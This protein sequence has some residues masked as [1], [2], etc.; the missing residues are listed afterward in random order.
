MR[1]MTFA[2]IY[3]DIATAAE[4]DSVGFPGALAARYK[5]D[6]DRFEQHLKAIAGLDVDVG[7][8]SDPFTGP[9]CA[10]T[11][12]DGG[13]SAILAAEMLERHGWRG[14]FFIT[15]ER[16]DT[17][18]FLTGAQVANLSQRGH[19]IGSHSHSHP[20]YMGRL[21]RAAIAHEWRQSRAVLAQILGQAPAQAAVP[22]GFL[23]PVVIEEAAA[24]GYEVLMTSQPT[25]KVTRMGKLAVMG[26][27]TIW[28]T[29]SAR[30]ASGYA[31]G[32]RRTRARL[33]TEWQV[34]GLSKRM[35]P[36]AYELLRR[37][38]AGGR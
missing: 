31:C 36:R 35:S 33:W 25:T 24:A 14:H 10:L 37:V 21:D 32:E 27:Y 8:V 2:L 15:T 4:G 1:S 9:R 22:G 5:L 23:S 38:R 20:T 11:F 29:T 13:A 6:P 3:H 26:R 34:K 18:G 30:Q 17:L 28:S 16:I 7:L 19:V 12:D